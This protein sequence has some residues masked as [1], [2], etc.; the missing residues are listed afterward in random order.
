MEDDVTASAAPAPAKP[1]IDIAPLRRMFDDAQ[2]LTRDART[3]SFVDTDYYDGKQWTPAEREA[4]RARRQ[5]DN[6]FNRIRAAINGTL[7]VIEKG[8]S[9]PRA[10]PR[11][12]GDDESSDVASKTLRYI[13]DYNR[14]ASIKRDVSFD[15][16]VPGTGAAIVEVD[17]DRKITVQ[18]IRFEEFF[19]DPR[20]RRRD[21]KDARYM[22]V[23][24]WMYADDV[25][26]AYGEAAADIESI[27][28]TGSMM[29]IDETFRDRP[30][31]DTAWIDRRNR[32]LLVV[33]IYYRTGGQWNRCVFHG[34]GALE[35]GPSPYHDEKGRPSCPIEAQSCYIDR[36]NNRYGLVR[37]M[38]GPQDEINKRRSKLLALTNMSQIQAVDPSAIDVDADTARAEAAKPDGVIPFGWQKVSTQDMATGQ[39]LLLQE[40]K[41]EI[42]RMGQSPAVLGR[43]GA[44]ASGRSV[45]A[46]QQA[47]LTES[48]IIFS[49]IEDWELRIYRQKW[50]RARQFWTDPMFVRVTDDVKAPEF[51]GI[52]QPVKGPPQPVQQYDEV[53]G[54]SGWTMYEPILGYKNRLG[55]M[56]VDI[57]LDTTPDTANLQQEQFLALV[58][59]ARAGIPIPPDVLV[60]ASS[61]PNKMELLERLRAP[62]E[63][64]PNP[65]QQVEI[66]GK[67]ADVE[68]TRSETALNEAKT[69]TMVGEA[70]MQAQAVGG[71]GAPMGGAPMG[72]AGPMPPMEPMGPPPMQPEPMG[73]PP[74]GNAFLTQQ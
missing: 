60:E 46:R 52:N 59:L 23:A 63:Q 28:D 3:E 1:A 34:C 7:G 35:A 24:K 55:E 48:A 16:L 68:K 50:A 2:T 8:A 21:W 25:Q 31:N 69:L 64:G 20:S 65:L 30:L 33:E 42:E 54:Q 70:A 5:P 44:D 15:I 72:P 66:E 58:D 36:D 39:S 49:G 62:Q 19:G 12:P 38:R 29:P 10:H 13:A 11:N 4:L 27:I 26:A 61:L 43:Q 9:D 22:G 73:G 41:A 67:V 74:P 18:Q 57:I 71:M 53:T 47:G 37:D 6:V 32:R 45:L 51:V 56:D 17:E 40:S 14:F